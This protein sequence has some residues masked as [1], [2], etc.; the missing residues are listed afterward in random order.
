MVTLIKYGNSYNVNVMKIDGLSTA[1]KPIDKIDGMTIPNGSVYTEIDTNTSFRFDAENKTWHEISNGYVTLDDDG[2]IPI[3]YIPPEIIERMYTVTND[4][5]RF[6]LTT[7]EV[8][9]GDV[10][11]VNSTQIMYLVKDDTK[12]S[13]EAGYKEFA[14]GIA[15]RAIADE[16]GNNIKQT[17]V[18]KTGA[19]YVPLDEN[20]KY[21][22]VNGI[23]VYVSGTEPTGSIPEGSLGIGF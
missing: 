9:N 14:A 16:D 22:T 12:L 21:Y 2:F 11:Y 18:K 8:Q 10:V 19:Q 23:R 20:N 3:E 17:Y 7:D 5:A 1:Q 6:A 4:T 13:S 15:G